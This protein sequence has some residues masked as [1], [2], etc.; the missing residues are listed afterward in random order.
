MSWSINFIGKPQNVI[1]ALNEHSTKLS[2]YSK[3]E[4]DNALPHLVGLVSQNFNK[5]HNILIKIAASGHGYKANGEEKY[6]TCAVTIEQIYGS[7]V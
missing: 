3:E 6:R 2:D 5:D 4:Y 1:N 7:L